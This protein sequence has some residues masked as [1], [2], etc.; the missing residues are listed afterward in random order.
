MQLLIHFFYFFF[1]SN[2][3]IAEEIKCPSGTLLIDFTP[4][5]TRQRV[6]MCQKKVDGKFLKHGPEIIYNQ[7]GSLRS[8]SYYE[9]DKI[10]RAPNDNSA[11]NSEVKDAIF[12]FTESTCLLRKGALKCWGQNTGDGNNHGSTLPQ[13]VLGLEDS[14]SSVAMGILRTCAVYQETQIKCWS[15]TRL[16]D[17][18][19]LK[20][21]DSANYRPSLFVTIND[22]IK[23]MT[24]GKSKSLCAL[25]FGNDV[26]CFYING[27][28]FKLPQDMSSGIEM[29]SMNGSASA[30]HY[31]AKKNSAVKCWGTWTWQKEPVAT[32]LLMPDLGPKTQS[33]VTGNLQDCFIDDGSVKCIGHKDLSLESSQVPVNLTPTLVKGFE[34]PVSAIAL[35]N[36]HACGLMNNGV[37][38]CWGKN[39]YGQLGE[40]SV[41]SKMIATEVVR[42]NAKAVSIATGDD[43]SCALLDNGEMKC[44]GRNSFGQLGQGKSGGYSSVPLN[45]MNL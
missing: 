39:H 42:L 31:C 20:E 12:A 8:K 36:A 27:N 14:V 17:L 44:W 4:S 22:K 30:N 29:I 15:D 25:T 41:E 1:S 43:H 7:D 10:V 5:L 35:G 11:K 40:G 6:Q 3:L 18:E 38:K 21:F 9:M 34:A 28:P 16:N 33:I 32:P 13:Q 23:A 19:N 37:V 24:L 45:V 26:K 2:L